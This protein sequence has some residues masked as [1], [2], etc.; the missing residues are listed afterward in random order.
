MLSV[1]NILPLALFSGTF[2][3][4]KFSLFSIY[5][6]QQFHSVPLVHYNWVPNHKGMA[7]TEIADRESRLQIWEVVANILNKQWPAGVNCGPLETGLNEERY[8]HLQHKP[9]Q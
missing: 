2:P 5:Y 6:Y 1:T 4:I 9:L 8:E 7:R 3:F